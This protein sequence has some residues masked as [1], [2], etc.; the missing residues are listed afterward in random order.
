M[1]ETATLEEITVSGTVDTATAR[2]A[3]PA[4]PRIKSRRMKLLER[5]GCFGAPPEGVTV[6]RATS[7]EDL[8]DAYRLVHDVFREQ[9]YIKPHPSGLR[10]RPFE[11]LPSTATFVARADG[12]VVGV[13]SVVIDSP[14]LG[15][16]TDKAF[17]EDLKPLRDAGRKISEGTNWVVTPEY[18]RTNLVSEL[19]RCAFAHSK[20]TGCDDLLATVSPTHA[21][22][23]DLLRFERIGPQRDYGKEGIEDPVVL[24]RLP[25]DAQEERFSTADAKSD[26]DEGLLKAYYMEGNPYHAKAQIWEKKAQDTPPDPKLLRELFVDRTG[27]LDECDA[28][29]LLPIKRAWGNELYAAVTGF[30][31]VPP[32]IA[33][34]PEHWRTA[35]FRLAA[36]L[37]NRQGHSARCSA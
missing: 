16:P 18:R 27:L 7:I 24:Y 29:A 9:H 33:I 20:T 2:A 32:H 17:L 37:A 5:M 6:E 10:V 3:E 26:D 30:A 28:Q 21:P 25:V 13:T 22:F 4:K 35:A 15:L 36:V 1:T 14:G 11:A 23:Y 34:S 19:M 8:S 12:E 31:G